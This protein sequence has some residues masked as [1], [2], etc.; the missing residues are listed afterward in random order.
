MAPTLLDSSGRARW[1]CAHMPMTRRSQW[2][3]LCG[4]TTVSDRAELVRIV[5]FLMSAK[6]TEAEQNGA[7]KTLESRV[8]HPRVSNLIFW[9]KHEGFDRELT[10]EEVVDVAMAYRPIEL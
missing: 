8:L 9:P 10:P 7:L 1:K 6:G 2:R 3:M 5:T 4:M